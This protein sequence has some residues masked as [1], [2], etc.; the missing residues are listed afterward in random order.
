[1]NAFMMRLEATLGKASLG[2]KSNVPGQSIFFITKKTKFAYDTFKNPSYHNIIIYPP[3]N[4]K[5]TKIIFY[6]V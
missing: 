1:M 6:P 4:N 2:F 5:S 3:Q